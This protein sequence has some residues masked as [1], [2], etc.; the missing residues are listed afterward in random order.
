VRGLLHIKVSSKGLLN[1]LHGAESF[2]RMRDLKLL[3]KLRVPQLMK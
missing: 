1:Q 2:L 3:E